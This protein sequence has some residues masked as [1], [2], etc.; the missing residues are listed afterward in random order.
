MAVARCLLYRRGMRP[1][2]LALC[3]FVLAGCSSRATSHA[4]AH[5]TTSPASPAAPVPAAPVPQHPLAVRFDG[6]ELLGYDL[7]NE[8]VPFGGTAHVTWYWHCTRPLPPG[9]RQLTWGLDDHS[10]PRVTY[11]EVG[12][13]RASHFPDAWRPGE[14]VTDAQDV[15]VPDDLLGS[16]LTLALGFWRGSDHL[17]VLDGPHDDAQLV[18]AATIHLGFPP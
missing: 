6:V 4:P 17:P 9:Y 10:A 5:T 18:H 8:W 13:V 7:D 11:D 15:R 16:T 12:D 3:A 1:R 2:H 14:Y